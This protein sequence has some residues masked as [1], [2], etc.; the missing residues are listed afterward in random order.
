M[1]CPTV[2]CK[3][4][5]IIII[6]IIIQI[7]LTFLLFFWEL[8]WKNTS[9]RHLITRRLVIRSNRLSKKINVNLLVDIA[10]KVIKAR[11]SGNAEK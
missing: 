8:K 11:E 3:S 10:R 5:N 6:N 9:R 4:E 2:F 7:S 1:V